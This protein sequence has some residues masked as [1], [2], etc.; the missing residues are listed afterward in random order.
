MR[1][2]DDFKAL[3]RKK[4]GEYRKHQRQKRRIVLYSV[5]SAAACFALCMLL[6]GSGLHHLSDGCLLAA[7]EQDGES[8]SGASCAAA[9]NQYAVNVGVIITSENE[10]RV[11]DPQT[12]ETLFAYFN[13]YMSS[14]SEGTG[15]LFIGDDDM[16]DASSNIQGETGPIRYSLA[17]TCKDGSVLLYEY[18][19]GG[20]LRM[21]CGL[22]IIDEKEA[23]ELEDL[24][25]QLTQG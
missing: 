24:L 11:T 9:D 18:K 19:E 15:L 23:E 6:Y 16:S 25:E 8:A 22:I 3:I 12:L 21:G 17:F 7:G 14:G 1:S 4:E 10:N 5:P 2:R 20:Y 13:R